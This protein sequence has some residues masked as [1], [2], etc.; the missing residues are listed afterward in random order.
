MTNGLMARNGHSDS[1]VFDRL[2]SDE[3]AEMR[4]AICRLIAPYGYMDS[5]PELP[6]AIA[7]AKRLIEY[8]RTATAIKDA[9]EQLQGQVVQHTNS[10]KSMNAAANSAS[11]SVTDFSS[12][13]DEILR[14]FRREVGRAKA[15][16]TLRAKQIAWAWVV[17]VLFGTIF[18]QM[19][20]AE[21]I[22]FGCVTLLPGFCEAVTA[23]EAE[24]E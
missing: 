2:T 19:L 13:I 4:E 14:V 12:N 9:I 18:G 6:R 1:S 22:S 5:D 21:A 8:Q 20:L 11:G 3:S 24:A 16:N 7:E 17:G 23:R 15:P 10:A